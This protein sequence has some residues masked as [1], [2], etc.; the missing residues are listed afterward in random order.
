MNTHRTALAAVTLSIA[1]TAVPQ[2]QAIG[3][4]SLYQEAI[5]SDPQL[6]VA[7]AEVEIGE[8]Q[9]RQALGN[10]L[11]QASAS[12]SVS[13]NRYNQTTEIDYTGKRNTLTIRQPLFNGESWYELKRS[14][15]NTDKQRALYEDK[16]GALAL[17][18]TDRY[19]NVL[20]SENAL[21]LAEAEQEAT[22][23]QLEALRSR[24]KRQLAVKTDVLDVEARLQAIKVDVLEAGNSVN[25]AR[26]G[27][28][29]MINRPVT[30]ELDDF[31]A[32]IPYQRSERTLEEW[33]DY[34]Y[35]NSSLYKSL[36]EEVKVAQKLVRARRSGHFPTLDLQL[37]A[38]RSN[39]GTE[40]APTTTTKSYTASLNLSVPIFS[41]GR[42]SAAVRES[43]S[44]LKI[45]N[46]RLEQLRRELRKGVRESFLNTATG[47]SRIAAGKLTI[48]ATTKSHEAM[49]QGLKY[50]TV[51]VVDVL[52][53]LKEKLDSELVYKRA[54]YD[55]VRNYIQL[56]R[57][58]GNLNAELIENVNAWQKRN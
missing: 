11:P 56:Q 48:A 2:A 26:E 40:N 30:E 37:N 8:H 18:L 17:D 15:H 23:L 49:R 32:T 39:I 42:T 25:I 13:R 43:H 19:L 58:S 45:A 46:Y 34:A 28:T 47:W 53:S 55:F 3:L 33:V 9:E 16:R 31:D 54:Q 5:V 6:L 29:E 21:Q 7:E 51:T 12:A 14:Q 10:L 24:Q 27:L 52:D 20:I 35:Q 50:G 1:I 41:G 57:L 4:L 22:Q 38:Q 36:Q 44:R